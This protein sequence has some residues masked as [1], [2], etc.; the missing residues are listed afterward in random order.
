MNTDVERRLT[1]VL[2]RHAEDAMNRTDTQEELRELLSR[3]DHEPRRPHRRTTV[4][5]T[6]LAA[7]A[8][9]AAVFWAADLTADRA[10]PAPVRQP[11]GESV[12]IVE[13]FVDALE[14]GDAQGMRALMAPGERPWAGWRFDLR[15]FDALGFEFL[16]D[17][18][19]RVRQVV[20]GTE[21]ACT[22][23]LHALHSDELGRG[24]F[25]RNILTAIVDDGRVEYASNSLNYDNNGQAEHV[26]AI[27]D[28]IRLHH[29]ED[30]PLLIDGNPWADAEDRD[31]WLQLWER[32]G[33]EYVDAQS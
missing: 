12:L 21:V 25:D 24:P 26:D 32:Y 11:P 10:E 31:R 5:A 33:Q 14:A 22:Y 4:L 2:H 28:W 15:V 8:V 20:S 19:Q 27:S 3:G 30:A 7:A 6:G 17:P 16:R 1:E 23:A 9:A 18:C 13:R 29:P